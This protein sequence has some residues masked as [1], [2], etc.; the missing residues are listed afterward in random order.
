MA[1]LK[2][3]FGPAVLMA[4]GLGV[5]GV[6]GYGFIGLTGHTLPA[7]D[8]AALASLYLLVNI[9]GPGLFVALEQETS[10]A[11]S[12]RLAV[13]GELRPVV[14]H[15]LLHGL[16]MLVAVLALLGAISPVLTARALGGQW[17]LF[18]AVV[19]SVVT[20][21]GVYLVRG[22]LGGRQRFHGYAAT[23]G[24][25]GVARLLPCAV[26]AVSGPDGVLYALAFAAGS[27]FGALAG[28]P[29]LRARTVVDVHLPG[30]G[31]EPEA[32]T[33]GSM[34]RGLLL[35]VVGT[36]L[37]Q[38]VANLAPIVVTSRLVSDPTTA[39]AFASA[40]VLVR[41]PLFL[42]APVQAMLLPGITRAATTG[43]T[44][45]VW[46]RL[47]LV[48]LA[49]AG[50]GVP[51]AVL[52]FT[53]GP[54]AARVFFGAEVDLAGAVVGLLG[55]GTIALMVA[56]V[57]QPGLVAFGRHRYV[58]AAWVLGAVVLV[59]LLFLPGD[60]LRAAIAAQLAASVAVVAV[61][62]VGL[63][64]AIRGGTRATPPAVPVGG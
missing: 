13:G 25:E 60:P 23:L 20:S 48:L 61:M 63:F 24:V 59:G 12:A 42:F 11:T 39:Q 21:A 38:L 16:I 6:A 49:V 1:R 40:F 47:R 57:L 7:A 3:L 2:N 30:E 14:R 35:L 31:G 56:Q 44:A 17:G 46:A 9:I 34:G 18:A 53:V 58:T 33:F 29:G 64:R 45:T 32:S 51:A 19:L 27:G 15:A 36:L 8:A 26:I 50:I 54:L 55:V 28:L 52:S 37:M 5:V 62:A 22:L 10:R 43:D 4:A 41:V